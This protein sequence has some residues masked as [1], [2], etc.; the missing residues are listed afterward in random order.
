[1]PKFS[2]SVKRDLE[3]LRFDHDLLRLGVDLAQ[4]RHDALHAVRRVFHD[5]HAPRRQQRDLAAAAD[6]LG[7]DVG[8]QLRLRVQHF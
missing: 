7:E 5:H 2:F 3:D 4:Q 1:M 8:H 6:V